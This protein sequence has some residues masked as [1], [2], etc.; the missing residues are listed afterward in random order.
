[1]GEFVAKI[2]CSMGIARAIIGIKPLESGRWV[3]TLDGEPTPAWGEDAE[4]G[5]TVR[6][7]REDA[8]YEAQVLADRLQAVYGGKQW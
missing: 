5:A 1:M 8:L 6:E 2:T 7:T 4:D 3:V